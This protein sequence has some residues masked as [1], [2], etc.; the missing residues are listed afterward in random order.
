[1][2]EEKLPL[3]KHLTEYF[4][5]ALAAVMFLSLPVI[6]VA[7][8]RTML[9]AII[10]TGFGA[11]VFYFVIYAVKEIAWGRQGSG[12]QA[13]NLLNG[14]YVEDFSSLGSWTFSRMETLKML[15]EAKEQMAR[16]K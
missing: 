10:A 4:L 9:V 1:M 14:E 12:A 16:R 5:D 11:G 3:L 2:A 7:W 13:T 6:W 8:S 15:Q